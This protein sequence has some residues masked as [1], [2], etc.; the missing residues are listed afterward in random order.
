MIEDIGL[1]IVCGGD[2]CFVC[3]EWF[4]D[5]DIECVFMFGIFVYDVDYDVYLISGYVG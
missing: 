4:V 3:C 5:G 2:V 1:R